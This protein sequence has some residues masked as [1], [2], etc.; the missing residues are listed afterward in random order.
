MVGAKTITE[1]KVS[2]P[3]PRT[4]RMRASRGDAWG[5]L[6]ARAAMLP[7]QFLFM[8][9][10]V[11]IV[12]LKRCTGSALDD[13]LEDV[14]RLRIEV[15][16]QFPYL[17][18]GDMAYE[19]RYLRTY[20]DCPQAVVVVA[21]DGD[22]VVGASTGIPMAFEEE[23]F[24]RP[25]DQVGIDPRRVFYCA[26]SVLEAPY[27]GRGLGV[28]FFEEREAHARELGGF[29]WYA[30]CAVLR[31]RNHPRRP[32]DYAPLDD[33]WRR[34]GYDKRPDLRASYAWKDLDDAQETSKTMEFWLKSAS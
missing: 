25:F 29:D 5:P 8:R 15:F 14:A 3:T 30:F 18:D 20:A 10:K 32:A 4:L 17:Y 16:R 11:S 19:E 33:F 9:T 31:P 28:R 22:R 7:R 27:R 2:A 13:Y 34:R 24:R 23:D 12:T 1:G 21:L 26:E 6:P